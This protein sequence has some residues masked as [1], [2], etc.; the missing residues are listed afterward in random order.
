MIIFAHRGASAL[1]PANSLPAFALAR[2][3]GATHYE[4]DVHLSKDGQLVIHHDY[5]L[6]TDTICPLDIKQAVL[7][8]IT[9]SRILHD[10]DSDLI[11]R[12][13]LLREVI[14]VIME[15]LELLNIEIKNDDNVYPGIEK[16]LW[17]RVKSFGPEAMDKILFS[18]FDYPTLQRLRRL[19][20]Q[21][22]IGLLTRFFEPQKVLSL[23]AESVHI[24]QTRIT[25]EMIDWC[26][27]HGVRV[28]V[29]VVNDK[30]TAR[31]LE[32]KGVDGIFTDN[33]GLFL[34]ARATLPTDMKAQYVPLKLSRRTRSSRKTK[35][36][37]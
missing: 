19:A 33:P 16:I 5:N 17:N 14:P 1:A 36:P 6:G 28:F 2:Q 24:N 25:Q 11:V 30:Y 15:E 29:Y 37:R 35:N 9:A 32:R 26:H 12:P 8:D 3:Q 4:L 31:Q 10:F 20:P 23:K 22:R 13:P 27:E 34:P 21:A 7:S 18:S